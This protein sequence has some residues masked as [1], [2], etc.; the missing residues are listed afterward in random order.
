[1]QTIKLTTK[2]ADMEAAL[3]EFSS[4]AQIRPEA[5]QTFL[6]SLHSPNEL[7]SLSSHVKSKSDIEIWI[8]PSA[9][10]SDFLKSLT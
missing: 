1:M 7:V 2:S 5:A 4:L 9:R 3:S 8:K 10:F 6:A